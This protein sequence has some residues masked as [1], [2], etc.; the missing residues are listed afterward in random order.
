MSK[1]IKLKMSLSEDVFSSYARG[2]KGNLDSEP[3]TSYEVFRNN[4]TAVEVIV[5]EVPRNKKNARTQ[6]TIESLETRLGG[7]V[8][9]LKKELNKANGTL[10]RSR[11]EFQMCIREMK[12]QIDLTNQ[13]EMD[14][15]NKNLALL[16]ENEKLKTVLNA[17]TNLVNK[18]RTE[19][20]NL[21]RI[22]KFVVKSIL[23][24]PKLEALSANCSSDPEYDDFEN[25]LKKDLKI[26]LAAFDEMTTFDS[27]MSKEDK[28][29]FN[30]R[31][32]E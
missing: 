25:S 13:R 29:S 27:T 23:R 19:L 9:R 6:D 18:L 26:K 8:D 22:I 14:T 32:F 15:R 4:T 10:E 30:K 20:S 21:K 31:V 2:K 5:K 24:E 3:S 11:K 7:D 1:D 16:L 12:K 28:T 17:K